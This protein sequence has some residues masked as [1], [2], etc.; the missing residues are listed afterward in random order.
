MVEEDVLGWQ[1]IVAAAEKGEK[2]PAGGFAYDSLAWFA[3]RVVIYNYK[4]GEYD[5]AGKNKLVSAI[6]NSWCHAARQMND[7]L[8]KGLHIEIVEEKHETN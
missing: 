8:E 2:L 7:A 6:F 4:K 5:E 1:D 3:L